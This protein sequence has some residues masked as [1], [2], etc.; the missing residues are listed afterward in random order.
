VAVWRTK[1]AFSVY[2]AGWAGMVA[3][4]LLVL[5][6]LTLITG[7][8]QIIALLTMP[9]FAAISA[10]FYVSLW[11]SFADTFGAHDVPPEPTAQG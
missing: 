4:A 11:F 7:L 2:M 10:A 1:A 6:M 3:A 8:Q 9:L 5:L